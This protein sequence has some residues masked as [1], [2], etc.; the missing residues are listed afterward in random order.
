[1]LVLIP[2]AVDRF[3]A[4]AFP[5]KYSSIVTYKVS[6][7]MVVLSWVPSVGVGLNDAIRFFLGKNKVDHFYL[8][9]KMSLSHLETKIMLLK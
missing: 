3:I 7:A 2:M 4:V 8:F 1:M 5:V 6:I 9:A